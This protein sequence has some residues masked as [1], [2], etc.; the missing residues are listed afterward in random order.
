MN[1]DVVQLPRVLLKLRIGFENHVILI[2]LR[3]QR[4]NLPL[5]ES[6]IQRVVDGRRRYAEARRSGA[7][8]D[9]RLRDAA[10]LLVGH[11]VGEFR[12][13]RQLRDEIVHHGVQL[14]LIRI[15]K[16]VLVFGT[17]HP[18]V[19]GKVLHRLHIELDPRYLCEFRSQP[20]DHL[21]RADLAL[22]ERL[23]ID[24]NAAAIER[25]VGAVRADE[26]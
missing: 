1:V 15:F 24:L 25:R 6:V 20:V 14:R 26:R 4:V 8:D 2:E 9:Q 3:V 16:R 17:A 18:V 23:E 10:Q 12:K 13:P 21:R 7:V 22:I 19:N 5:S 11:H